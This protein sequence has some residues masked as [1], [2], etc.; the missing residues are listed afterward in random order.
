MEG[1][2]ENFIKPPQNEFSTTMS[3]ETIGSQFLGKDGCFHKC[4]RKNK[5]R[6]RGRTKILSNLRKMNFLLQCPWKLLA[7]YFEERIF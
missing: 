3:L 4:Y 2:N 1:Q 7:Y 5:K 6:W